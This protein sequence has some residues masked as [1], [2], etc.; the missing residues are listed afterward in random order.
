MKINTNPARTTESKL[1][2][3]VLN[4]ANPL[5][6]RKTVSVTSTSKNAKTKNAVIKIH[7]T[8]GNINSSGGKHV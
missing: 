5:E 1:L 7:T 3:K 8:E 6:V 4:I 2:A